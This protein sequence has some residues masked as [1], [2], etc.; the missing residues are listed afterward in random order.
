MK[1][2]KST[3]GQLATSL[4]SLEMEC[5]LFVSVRGIVL[6]VVMWISLFILYTSPRDHNGVLLHWKELRKYRTKH[7]DFIHVE[8][9]TKF[10]S[11][12]H[13]LP[14][15]TSSNNHKPR[16]ATTRPNK[17]AGALSVEHISDVEKFVFFVG[18][19]RSGH[20][21]VG[22]MLDAHPNMIVAHEFNLFHQL[23]HKSH[24][25]SK[26]ALFNLLYT[27]SYNNALNG[28]RSG[29]K[30]RKGYTLEVRG[31]SQGRFTKL[32]VIGDKSGGQTGQE[33]EASPS[34]FV[35]LYRQLK[36]TVG[37]P[38]RAIHVV[39]NPYDMISTRVLY[40]DKD[41]PGSRLSTATEEHK[42]NNTE[43]LVLQVNRTFELMLNVWNMI[44]DCKLTVLDIHIVDLIHSPRDTLQR[45]CDFLDLECP[46]DYLQA[47]TNK[48]Y[49][50]VSKTRLLV[51]WPQPLRQRVSEQ[52]QRYPY[53]QGYTF[54]GD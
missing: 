46:E 1:A 41:K 42:Y 51:E 7:G 27:N 4:V 39:R 43:H 20:S 23:R 54:E 22:S 31:G 47:C 50:G 36:Q 28:W 6:A 14:G 10:I 17:T 38:V 48:A 25:H 44:R 5:K 34:T 19:P 16:S 9:S 15:A 24:T 32:K 8:N 29:R 40:R 33:Y 37:V 52:I 30:E 2:G 26:E 18:Y 35:H 49:T 21:I 13:G 45:V 12:A 53:F 3:L 11:E